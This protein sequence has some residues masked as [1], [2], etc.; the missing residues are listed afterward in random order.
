MDSAEFVQISRRQDRYAQRGHHDHDTHDVRLW[1]LCALLICGLCSPVVAQFSDSFETPQ[2]KWSLLKT[3]GRVVS[4]SHGKDTRVYHHGSQSEHI[5]LVSGLATFIHYRYV[6]PGVKL[7]DEINP[8]LWIRASRSPIQ[9][10]AQVVLPR[11]I[12][13]QTGQ[14]LEILIRGDSYTTPLRWQKLAITR[15][16]TRLNNQIPSL[17]SQFGSQVDGRQAYIKAVILNVYS[18]QGSL[19]LWIDSFHMQTPYVGP[20][21]PVEQQTVLANFQSPQTGSAANTQPHSNRVEIKD[22]ILLVNG[23]PFMP[24]IIEHNGESLAYLHQLGFN[25]IALKHF[26]THQQL[27]DAYRL[28]LKLIVP[29]NLNAELSPTASTEPI[30]NWNLGLHQRESTLETLQTASELIET[31]PAKLAR[32]TV[33]TAAHQFKQVSRYADLVILN[34]QPLHS[35]LTLEQSSSQIT[36]AMNELRRGTPYW[37]SIATQISPVLLQQQY[38]IIQ[39]QSLTQPS[40]PTSFQGHTTISYNQLAMVTH[41]SLAL[42][43][44]GIHFQSFSRLDRTDKETILRTRVLERLN[45]ELQLIEPWVSGGTST[46]VVNS[47]LEYHSVYMTKTGRTR[48][49]WLFNRGDHEQIVSRPNDDALISFDVPGVPVTYLPYHVN[50]STIHRIRT[51]RGSNN[52][53]AV[54]PTAPYSL[55]VMTADPLVRDYIQR[56]IYA[57]RQRILQLSYD[58]LQLELSRVQSL[59]TLDSITPASLADTF[60]QATASHRSARN[61]VAT[62]QWDVAYQHLTGAENSLRIIRFQAWQALNQYNHNLVSNPLNLHTSTFVESAWTT[63]GLQQSTWSPNL[64]PG[65][66]MEDLNLMR[67]GGWKHHRDPDHSVKTLVELT[68]HNPREGNRCLRIQAWQ[69][70]DL[71]TSSLLSAPVWISSPSVA[72]QTGDVLRIHGWVNIPVPLKHQGDG[73]VIYDSIT[74]TVLADRFHHTSGW[75]AFT[76]YRVADRNGEATVSFALMGLGAVNIDNISIQKQISQRKLSTPPNPRNTLPQTTSTP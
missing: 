56:Q 14:P 1:L 41:R 2:T 6:T 4:T 50:Y 66:S 67:R 70:P 69:D 32:P 37:I 10:I 23:I 34:W 36:Q 42:G 38:S 16:R 75:Q 3:D 20:T 57:N 47:P 73:L 33:A 60:N 30:L 54:T 44:R 65:S 35:S 15:I 55:V 51:N 22:S 26:P 24:R 74:G 76:L 45:R 11:S 13:P 12:D 49:V 53:I 48:L 39:S 21:S 31:L 17:R 71:A 52:R 59:R 19:D 9:L 18:T 68:S 62:N 43:A 58:I 27:E 28:N 72:V 64:L 40:Q 61:A 5:Q 29:P 8:S 63:R 7:I 25:T 46:G